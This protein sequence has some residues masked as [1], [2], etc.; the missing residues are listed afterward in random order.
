MNWSDRQKRWYY[1]STSQGGPFWRANACPVGWAWRTDGDD[2]GSTDG[3]LYFHIAR[4][5]K[6]HTSPPTRRE[7]GAR[8]RSERT[9]EESFRHPK[10]GRKNINEQYE[11]LRE[12]KMGLALP[13]LAFK[14]KPT[15]S[16]MLKSYIVN[17]IVS[18]PAK[19]SK[20]NKWREDQVCIFLC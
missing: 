6:V 12:T 5:G 20:D 1:S 14:P 18:L 3:K 7:N 9:S 4:P 15:S 2:R 8:K 10:R 13:P 17:G 16:G 19:E 11:S